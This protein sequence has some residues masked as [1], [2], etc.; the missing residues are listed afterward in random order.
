VLT[1]VAVSI[2]FYPIQVS[3]KVSW[4]KQAGTIFT[5]R[6]LCVDAFIGRGPQYFIDENRHCESLVAL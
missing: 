3:L 2:V 6:R 5:K 1:F 4:F